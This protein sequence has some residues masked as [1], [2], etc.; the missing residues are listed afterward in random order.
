MRLVLL[1][2]FEGFVNHFADYISGILNSEK[3]MSYVTASFIKGDV[4]I[5]ILS[6]YYGGNSTY[7]FNELLNKFRDMYP[8]YNLSVLSPRKTI[9]IIN[10]LTKEDFGGID[11]WFTFYKTDRP[12]YTQNQIENYKKL[13]VNND[14]Y[15]SIEPGKLNGDVFFP[16]QSINYT[17]T[18]S[19]VITSQYP[20]GYSIEYREKLY[21]A[22]FL[23]HNLFR[24]IKSDK[25]EMFFWVDTL[26][27][28]MDDEL[29]FRIKTQS[30][31]SE[32]KLKSLALDVLCDFNMSEC[33]SGYDITQDL[34]DPVS[35]KPW[36]DDYKVGEL[37]LF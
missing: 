8:F 14:G 4:D 32:S 33:I 10:N 13:Y 28:L 29:C 1:N 26:E 2:S 24:V 35:D 3:S 19:T 16:Q 15:S 17:N 18:L 23:A 25:I 6:G 22:E 5:I 20:H 37:I 11:S 9:K 27:E 12:I 30:R 34:T 21:S 7:N 31:W 36:L